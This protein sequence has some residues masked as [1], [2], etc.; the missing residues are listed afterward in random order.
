M[1][2]TDIIA[3]QSIWKELWPGWSAAG[4]IKKKSASV[5]LPDNE[6]KSHESYTGDYSTA[7]EK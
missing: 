5:T 3:S 6:P 2:P 4:R 1:L 7:E